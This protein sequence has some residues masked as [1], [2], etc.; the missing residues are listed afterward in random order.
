MKTRFWLP[1]AAA[2]LLT[3]GAVYAQRSTGSVQTGNNTFAPNAGGRSV[4]I[5]FFGPGNNNGSVRQLTQGGATNQ[6]TG[7][8]PQPFAPGS[9]VNQIPQT[10]SFA[11]PPNS[12]NGSFGVLD[13]GFGRENDVFFD[14]TLGFVPTIPGFSNSPGSGFFFPGNSFAPQPPLGYGRADTNFGPNISGLYPMRAVPT[15][16]MNAPP[17]GRAFGR[18]AARGRF[19]GTPLR[20]DFGGGV[21]APLREDLGAATR[22]RTERTRTTGRIITAGSDSSQ[23]NMADR[24]NAM[25]EDRAMTEATIVD[26]GPSRVKV[27][28]MDR[29]VER[30]A[31]VPA[32]EVIFFNRNARMMSAATE[33]D[34]GA[35]EQRGGLP[36]GAAHRAEHPLQ[37]RGLP[38][39]DA[40]AGEVRHR[41]GSSAILTGGPTGPPVLAYHGF[42]RR[43]RHD[44]RH[45]HRSRRGRD[46]HR[47]R[48]RPARLAVCAKSLPTQH[49]P[50]RT[51]R[52][53]PRLLRPGGPPG[54]DR[55]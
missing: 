22:V 45:R 17:L 8:N 40:P 41:G 44:R 54:H 6:F 51:A 34:L 19:R 42:R 4:G 2:T 32:D 11:I 50:A 14:P 35:A 27:R 25:M 13:N 16:G 7:A 47:A 31:N 52:Q 29:G 53:S 30:T 3:T 28:Y 20:E 9:G 24:V 36:P 37:A 18:T 5:P 15:A 48:Q 10:P 55:R 43:R 26:A 21:S 49:S 39:P 23:V 46:R 33:P 1:V 38:Q 12:F